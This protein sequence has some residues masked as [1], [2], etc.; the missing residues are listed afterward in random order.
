[1][2]TLTLCV[3]KRGGI[4]KKKCKE[5]ERSKKQQH[6]NRCASLMDVAG[7]GEI[8]NPKEQRLLFHAHKNP[9]ERR[10]R[11]VDIRASTDY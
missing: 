9:Q 1:M 8:I 10:E 7:E 3:I 2:T 4:G 5:R 6:L 11:G